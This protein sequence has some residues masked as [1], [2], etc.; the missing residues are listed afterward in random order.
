MG[1]GEATNQRVPNIT[2]E[3]G[4]GSS[5]TYVVFAEA[6]ERIGISDSTPILALHECDA[7]EL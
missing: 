7:L 3:E 6:I 2:R 5:L 4:S 1:G